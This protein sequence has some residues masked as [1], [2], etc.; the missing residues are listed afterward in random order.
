VRGS[1]LAVKWPLVIEVVQILAWVLMLPRVRRSAGSN[2]LT[3]SI[4][5]LV[6]RAALSRAG[7][8]S[9]SREARTTTS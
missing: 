5:V 8:R 1:R 4:F 3:A 9:V 7:A 6:V 2:H